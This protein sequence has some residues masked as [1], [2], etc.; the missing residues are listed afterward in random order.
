MTGTSSTGRRKRLVQTEISV[1]YS[2]EITSEISTCMYASVQSF[3]HSAIS[4]Y[5]I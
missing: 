2:C 1:V 5:L 3:S 4:G